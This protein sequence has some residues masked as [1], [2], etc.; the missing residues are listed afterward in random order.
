MRAAKESG[1][2]ARGGLGMLVGQARWR[3]RSGSAAAAHRGR[4]SPRRSPSSSARGDVKR[5]RHALA[6]LASTAL[7]LRRRDGA[8]EP[9]RGASGCTPTAPA[10][11]AMSTDRADAHAPSTTARSS[12]RSPPPLGRHVIV[13]RTPRPSS[14]SRTTSAPIGSGDASVP[15]DVAPTPGYRSDRGVRA[16]S[17]P[18]LGVPQRPAARFERTLW[19]VRGKNAVVIALH[20][21]RRAPSAAQ[22]FARSCRSARSTR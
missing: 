19:L 15:V 7:A 8:I 3:S 2:A 6:R 18:A 13:S 22:R 16:G 5:K 11:T 10:P 17:D 4:S 12:P 20:H 9:R 21:A 1:R 14:T